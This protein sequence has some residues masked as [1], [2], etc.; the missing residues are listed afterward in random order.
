MQ[1]RGSGGQRRGSGWQRVTSSES[2]RVSDRDAQTY[3][4]GAAR[5]VAEAVKA[6]LGPTGL[7]KLL[8]DSS[9]ELVVT[10]D[11]ERILRSME[12][13]NPTAR[14]IADVAEAQADTVGDGTTSGVVLAG[15]LLG[16]AGDLLDRSVHPQSILEGFATARRTVETELPDLGAPVDTEDTELLRSVAETALTG[17][18]S[19]GHRRYLAKLVVE[20]V[21][22]TTTERGPQLDFVDVETEAGDAISESELFEGAIYDRELLHRGMPAELPDARV[23]FLKGEATLE[24]EIPGDERDFTFELETPED[25]QSLYD[26]EDDHRFANLDRITDANVNCVFCEKGIDDDSQQYLADAGILAIRRI[27]PSDLQ[28]FQRVLGGTVLTHLDDVD[29]SD[30]GTGMIRR[31]ADGERLYITGN[32]GDAVTLFVRAPT[33]MIADELERSV[34]DALRAVER[35]LVDGA[36]VP[37]AGATE[38]ALARRIRSTAAATD[39]RAQLAVEAVADAIEALPK[40]IVANAGGD[41]IDALVALR[42]AHSDGK[43]R[44]GWDVRTEEPVDAA[45]A[46]IVEPLSVK[47]QAIDSAI[48]AASLVLRID[49]IVAATDLEKIPDEN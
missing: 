24:P 3:N 48:E 46:G 26:L 5:S 36:V 40:T 7:D 27:E 9:G 2:E 23:L 16:N 41:G 42:A 21:Q 14:L 17:S 4:I 39:G 33:E 19:D 10:N 15:E 31:D 22:R 32:G 47:R 11:G 34:T 44:T 12:I 25:R 49:D 18:L 45:E 20:A 35:A 37:G 1:Q 6:T 29:E 43:P 30:V 28:F 13:A 8:I 38:V